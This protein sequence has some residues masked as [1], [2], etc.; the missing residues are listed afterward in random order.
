ML[1]LFDIDMT[2]LTTDG[3]GMKALGDAGRDRFGPGFDETRTDY[4]GRLDP[5]I[6]HDL[7]MANGIEPVAEHA[8]A[9][10]AGYREHLGRRLAAR[11]AQALAGAA[12]LVDA[13]A[14]QDSVMLGVLTGNFE[15]TGRLKLGSAGI[16]RAEFVLNVWGD[17]SPHAPPAR[18]HLPAVAIERYAAAQRRVLAADRVLIIGDTVHDVSCAL[19]NGCRVLGVATGHAVARDLHEAGAHR[20]ETDLRDTEGIVRWIMQ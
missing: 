8:A 20:V 2:L 16:E 9:L 6:I 18:A 15:E 5:L 19:A 12:E 14:E 10:R 17:E 4:G 13:L 7:L 11:P 1:V 3:A